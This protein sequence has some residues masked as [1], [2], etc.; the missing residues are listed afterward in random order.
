V[1]FQV[2]NRVAFGKPLAA[3]GTIQQDI[4]KSRC[5][6]EQTRL[7]VLKAAHM[8]DTVGNKVAAPEISMIKVIA[9]RMGQTVLDRAIQVRGET[10]YYMYMYA[11]IFIAFIYEN[12]NF[13]YFPILVFQDSALLISFTSGKT[14]GQNV[15]VRISLI[16]TF[17]NNP[18]TL[19]I[20]T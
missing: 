4:A 19:V 8:M 6:I 5:E 18:I 11:V 10:Y 13:V 15:A 17:I 2:Q 14:L 9:P 3:Q 20:A 12:D 1:T 16:Y 7:L